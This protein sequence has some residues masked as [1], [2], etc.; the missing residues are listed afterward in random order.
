MTLAEDLLTQPGT[1]IDTIRSRLGFGS[2][3]AFARAFRAYRGLTPREYRLS[4]QRGRT[5]S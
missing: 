3:F 2:G 1:P 5:A 4:V